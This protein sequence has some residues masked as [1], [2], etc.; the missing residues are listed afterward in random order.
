MP[1]DHVSRS[2]NDTYYIDTD[3]VLRCHTSA[4]QAATLRQGQSAFL[5][6][7]TRAQGIRPAWAMRA[8]SCQGLLTAFH[9][10]G[11]KRP[12]CRLEA[13]AECCP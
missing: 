2:P 8:M 9:F 4:H 7:G 6:T 1:A 11:R 3:T 13:A 10:M 5:I 12:V